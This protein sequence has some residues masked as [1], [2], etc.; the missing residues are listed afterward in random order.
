[1]NDVIGILN[2]G[3]AVA[4]FSMTETGKRVLDS[5]NAL[6]VQHNATATRILNQIYQRKKQKADV[7]EE[8]FDIAT[9]V[10]GVLVQ[11]KQFAGKKAQEKD[12]SEASASFSHEYLQAYQEIRYLQVVSMLQ[13]VTEVCYN[14]QDVMNGNKL[15]AALTELAHR[16]HVKLLPSAGGFHLNSALLKLG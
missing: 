13:R 1:M 9:R 2:S 7:G 14:K 16:D 12:G 3:K 6:S 4:D 15:T 10:R 5:Q 11:A 8:L